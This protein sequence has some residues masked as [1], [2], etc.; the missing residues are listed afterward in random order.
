[1]RYECFSRL[2]LFE[3]GNVNDETVGNVTFGHLRPR[4]VD[5]L[6]RDDLVVG[7]DTLLTAEVE[8]FLGLLDA[9]NDGA[10][11]LTVAGDQWATVQLL[12]EDTNVAEDAQVAEGS[13]KREVRIKVVVDTHGV[14]EKLEVVSIL[15]ELLRVARRDDVVGTKLLSLGVLLVRARDH[16]NLGTKRLGKLGA[17]VAKTAETS[18]GNLAAFADVVLTE[19]RVGGDTSAQDGSH[20]GQKL[21]LLQA[22]RN[23][24]DE[25]LLNNDL[26]RVTTGSGVARETGLRGTVGAD[27]ALLAEHLLVSFAL[28]ALAAGV[29]HAADSDHVADLVFGDVLANSADLTDDLV[30][31]NNRVNGAGPVAVGGVEIRVAHTGV[32][33]INQDIVRE[34]LTTLKLVELEGSIRGLGSVRLNGERHFNLIGL[35]FNNRARISRYL[36]H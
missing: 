32:D 24:H 36:Y 4:L 23:L 31:S 9:T 13:K 35:S 34:D 16:S 2:N 21:R 15:L 8:E 25:V 7:N 20:T 19:R 29:D 1:M 18:D 33:N 5:L 12:L 28:G 11:E 27:H 30:A 10:R 26:L 14:K 3:V 6:H 17:H 22:L